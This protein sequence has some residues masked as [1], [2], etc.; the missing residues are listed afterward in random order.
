LSTRVPAGSV[1]WARTPGRPNAYRR[2]GAL[3]TY[4]SCPGAD[5][6]GAGWCCA[7]GSRT[8]TP[9]HPA[10]GSARRLGGRSKS[11]LR[12]HSSSPRL[13]FTDVSARV[14]CAVCVEPKAQPRCLRTSRNVRRPERRPLTPSPSRSSRKCPVRSRSVR[15]LGRSRSALWER[16]AR[17][18]VR[19]EK[20]LGRG[21][22]RRRPVDTPRGR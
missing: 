21:G 8:A 15:T 12:A 6:S 7:T 18:R 1:A 20:Q 4:A 11:R 9:R 14:R 17:E 10:G 16:S 19:L 2:A 3:G 13:G 22:G 5:P